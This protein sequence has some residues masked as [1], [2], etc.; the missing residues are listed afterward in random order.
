[1]AVIPVAVRKRIIHL[2][3]SG[4]RTQEIASAL[5]FC[6]AAVRR[7]RQH[8]RERGTLEPRL[9]LRGR[10]GRFTP[11]MAE[12]L[13]Q[14]VQAR[15][16]ATLAELAQV[17]LT[18]DSTVDRWLKKLGLSLKKSRRTRRSRTGRT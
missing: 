1:M 16:D 6:K 2:Y 7:I 8:L 5:G 14:A 3:D 9:H 4:K 15:P 11:Q 13:R 12:Q 17:L 10:K 18:S